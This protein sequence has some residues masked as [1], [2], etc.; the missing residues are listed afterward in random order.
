MHNPSLSQTAK[1]L[2]SNLYAAISGVAAEHARIRPVDFCNPSTTWLRQAR[3]A[4]VNAI[5]YVVEAKP[6]LLTALDMPLTL[7][8][9]VLR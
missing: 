8:R 3:S 6:G 7:P 9:H 4:R 2:E 5:P 1:Q